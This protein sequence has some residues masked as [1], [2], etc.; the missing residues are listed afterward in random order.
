MKLDKR[1]LLFTS[2]LSFS[3]NTAGNSCKMHFPKPLKARKQTQTATI[4]LVLSSWKLTLSKSLLS[5][6]QTLNLNN[7]IN[8]SGI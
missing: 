1:M 3:A 4:T 8:V 2:T 7:Q 5:L 6:P